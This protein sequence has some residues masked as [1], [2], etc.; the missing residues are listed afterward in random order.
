MIEQSLRALV[1]EQISPAFLQC[2]QME[3]FLVGSTLTGNARRAH[4][5]RVEVALGDTGR[6]SETMNVDSLISFVVRRRSY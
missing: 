6:Q 1:A 3:Q 2:Y 4:L 5:D